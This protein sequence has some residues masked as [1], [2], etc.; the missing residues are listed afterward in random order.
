MQNYTHS[1]G[2]K[3]FVWRKKIV[4]SGIGELIGP[5]TATHHYERFKIVAIDQDG[6][7]KRYYTSHIRPFLE[8]PSMLDDSIP[9]RKIED[10]HE[11]V[12]KG[13]DEPG[14]P[15]YNGDNVQM[16]VDLQ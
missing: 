5:F 3:V 1:P 8:Q 7:I 13:P 14:E 9:E 16:N 15:E 10:R 12:N 2:D 4:N 11:E 6:V